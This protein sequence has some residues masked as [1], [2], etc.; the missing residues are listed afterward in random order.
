VNYRF[1]LNKALV[2]SQCCW[3][4]PDLPD[5]SSVCTWIRVFKH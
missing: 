3:V 2:M 1:K 5:R 4:M